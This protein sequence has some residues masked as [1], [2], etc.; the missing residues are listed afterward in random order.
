VTADTSEAVVVATGG[1]TEL[2]RIAVHRRLE[3][4]PQREPAEAMT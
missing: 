1:R 3:P 2:G 4:R